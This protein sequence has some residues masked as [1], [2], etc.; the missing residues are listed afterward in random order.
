[1]NKEKFNV[2]VACHCKEPVM[3]SDGIKIENYSPNLAFIKDPFGKFGK[4]ITDPPDIGLYYVE[5]DHI[6]KSYK[7]EYQYKGWENIPKDSF[8]L[9]WYQFCPLFKKNR[10]KYSGY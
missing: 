10:R 1:M 5:V 7:S 9:I 3:M 8:D 6:C 2:L 4:P